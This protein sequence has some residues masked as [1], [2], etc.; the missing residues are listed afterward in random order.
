MYP[1]HYRIMGNYHGIVDEVDETDD[2]AEAKNLLGEYRFSFPRDYVLWVEV[3][4]FDSS[5]TLD[6]CDTLEE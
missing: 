4:I 1:N 6:S 3:Q 2:L 5:G